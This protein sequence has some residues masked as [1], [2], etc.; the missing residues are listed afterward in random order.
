MT[1]AL[2]GD[3][4]NGF[5]HTL[6][7]LFPYMLVMGLAFTALTAL[8]PCNDGGHWWQKRGLVTDLCYWFIVPVFVRYGRI[9]FSVLITVY[10]LGINTS[11]GIINFFEFGHGPV[12]R[13]PFWV[14]LG[15]YV[16][17]TE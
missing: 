4:I 15:L 16:V 14:Q 2:L 13:L 10:L 6:L 11:P 5:S 8:T 9:G 7:R 1:V 3:I 12:A 17:G